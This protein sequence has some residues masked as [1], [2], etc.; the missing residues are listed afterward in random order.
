MKHKIGGPRDRV[1]LSDIALRA[2]YEL[3]RTSSYQ[4]C[5]IRF[6]MKWTINGNAEV[7]EL[8]NWQQVNGLAKQRWTIY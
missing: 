7:A 3:P 5:K 1:I 6:D 8:Q 4:C 2:K